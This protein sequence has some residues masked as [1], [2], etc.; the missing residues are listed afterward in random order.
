MEKKKN[1]KNTDSGLFKRL[2]RLLSGPIINYRT[3]LP[4]REK[5]PQLD[6]YQSRFRSASGKQFKKSPTPVNFGQ[7]L[8]KISERLKTKQ[9]N[10]ETVCRNLGNYN[11]EFGAVDS[12]GAKS[13]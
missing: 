9:Q 8:Q 6:K 4:R 5:R 1:P 13:V 10:C 2:T 7:H 3:Q 11:F 12:K